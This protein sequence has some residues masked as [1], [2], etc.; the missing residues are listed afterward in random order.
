[1]FNKKYKF[2]KALEQYNNS[3][4]YTNG[5][6]IRQLMLRFDW[7]RDTS[8]NIGLRSGRRRAMMQDMY[9]WKDNENINKYT[10]KTYTKNPYW[11]WGRDLLW[12]AEQRK[13]KK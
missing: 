11:Q 7:N 3:N 9:D 5:E 10:R 8:G 2:Y 6:L 4:D 1:M 12:E 13:K